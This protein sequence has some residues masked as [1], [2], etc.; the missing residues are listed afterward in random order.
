MT[1]TIK[2]PAT[3]SD[4]PAP[5]DRADG[6]SG[7]AYRAEDAEALRQS[8][9]SGGVP[10]NVQEDGEAGKRASFDP[11]TGEVHGSGSGA[12]GGNSNEGFDDD[13]QSGDR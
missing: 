2:R 1:D 6:H 7:Q 9:P 4:A 12:G 8:D 11:V 13:D 5:F 10:S 3:G